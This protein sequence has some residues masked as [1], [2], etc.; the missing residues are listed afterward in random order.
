VLVVATEFSHASGNEVVTITCASSPT[1]N[2][3]KFFSEKLSI[4]ASGRS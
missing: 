1:D 2:D 3:A 4:A